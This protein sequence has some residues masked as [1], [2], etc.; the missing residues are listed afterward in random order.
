MQI[1]VRYFFENYYTVGYKRDLNKVCGGGHEQYN[2][3]NASN[4]GMY[5]TA[6]IA[7]DSV[8]CSTVGK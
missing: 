3:H 5:K 6:A 2:L 7:V 1:L 4:L 8:P